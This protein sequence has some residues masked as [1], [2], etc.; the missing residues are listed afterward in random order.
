MPHKARVL[1]G[2]TVALAALLR[3]PTL[4][5]QSFW[6]DEASTALAMGGGLGDLLSRVAD[7]EGMPPLYFVVAWVWSKAFGVDEV[8]LRSLSAL[9]GTATV[10]VA[11]QLARRLAGER[12]GLIA[13]LLTATSPFLVWY[14]QEARSYA[15]LV[16]L[17]ALATLAFVHALESPRARPA[18]LWGVAAAAALATH[19]F[20]AFLVA[21]EAVVLLWRAAAGRRAA[22]SGVAIVAA[23]GLALAPLAI[24]QRDGRVDWVSDTPLRTRALDVAKHWVAGPFGSPLDAAV[25]VGLVLALGALALALLRRPGAPAVAVAVVAAVAVAGP[26]ALAVV[27]PDYALD[28][29][30]VGALVPLLA[31]AAAGLGDGRA[32]LV[33]AGVL[34]ALF[35]AFT[36][37]IAVDEELQ[38]EDWR[39]VARRLEAV[40][41]TLVVT[42]ADGGP[43]LRWYLKAAPAD[44][45][46]PAARVAAVGSWRFGRPRPATPAPPGLSLRRRSDLPTAT[47][48][49]YDRAA[50][51]AVDPGA[52]NLDPG[53][54]PIVLLSPGA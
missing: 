10:P 20:A 31:L 17:C 27:G 52:L 5:E 16:A 51:A 1:L 46:A 24:A 2:A 30:L 29:Y 37:D 25:A 28:R 7:T 21:P 43:P 11:W 32:G 54:A 44:A 39:T 42:T 6:R 48:L 50:G 12:A 49:E 3:F 47:L 35:A 15:L 53:E 19:Y 9:I 34:A 18:L 4:G 13:A 45:S 26:V 38:R 8:G 41:G 23:A 14:S 40:P 22:L 36:V 33:A